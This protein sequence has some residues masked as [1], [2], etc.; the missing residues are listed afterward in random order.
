MDERMNWQDPLLTKAVLLWTGYGN[1]TWPRR[2]KSALERRFGADSAKWIALMESIAHDFYESKA[3]LEA[4]D[5]QEMWTM[6]IADFKKRHPDASDAI[7]KAL[8]W[9]YTFDYK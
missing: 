3:H 8:A 2:D 4:R 5:L 1:R 7:A 9:C 6:S